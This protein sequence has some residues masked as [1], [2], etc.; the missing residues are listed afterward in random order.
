MYYFLEKQVHESDEIS[1]AFSFLNDSGR[2]FGYSRE[3]DGGRACIPACPHTGKGRE[4]G[5]QGRKGRNAEAG[6]GRRGDGETGKA[7]REEGRKRR[8]ARRG[9]RI[10]FG[11]ATFLCRLCGHLV[12]FI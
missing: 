2:A 12:I 4:T 5:E 6:N 10:N 3:R 8:K 1:S 9:K 7:E 11:A